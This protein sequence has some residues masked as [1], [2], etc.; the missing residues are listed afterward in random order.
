MAKEDILGFVAA[1][2]SAAQFVDVNAREL[3]RK[4]SEIVNWLF[5]Q[6]MIGCNGACR[7]SDSL[8]RCS[9]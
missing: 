7:R 2:A 4:C 9:L 6:E 1:L 8:G 5:A 3:A